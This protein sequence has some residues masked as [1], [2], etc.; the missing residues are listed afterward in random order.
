MGAPGAPM[1]RGSA[2]GGGE[3]CTKGGVVTTTLNSEFALPGPAQPSRPHDSTVMDGDETLNAQGPSL[4]CTPKSMVFHNWIQ[5]RSAPSAV[6]MLSPNVMPMSHWHL[7]SC[8]QKPTDERMIIMRTLNTQDTLPQALKCFRILRRFEDY[9][10]FQQV[11]SKY[12]VRSTAWLQSQ[13][14]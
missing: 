8:P 12:W 3:A 7:M 1:T 6:G 10:F 9:I 4:Y 5:N 11:V 2:S 13:C 14:N